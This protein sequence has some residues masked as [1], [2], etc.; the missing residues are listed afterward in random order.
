MTRITPFFA[1]IAICLLVSQPVIGQWSLRSGS[2]R[3]LNAAALYS[4][5]NSIV[6]GG[7]ESN[8]A[9]RFVNVSPDTGST[10]DN[11]SDLVNKQWITSI[12]IPVG[13]LTYRCGRLGTVHRSSDGAKTWD[14]IPIPLSV[15]ARS[16]NSIHF[17]DSEVG[18]VVG[19]NEA[20]DSIQTIIKTSDGGQNWV[21]Q[22]DQ[23]D[24]W[25]K[26]IW[27]HD[28]QTGI[29]AGERGTILKTND[30][31]NNWE[32]VNPPVGTEFSNFNAIYFKDAQNG[33]MVGG[34]PGIDSVQI[35]LETSDGGASWSAVIDQPGGALNGIGFRT[36]QHGFAVGD[37]G[38]ILE[39]TDG[40]A[41]WTELIFPPSFNNLFHLNN[42]VFANHDY[43]LILGDFGQTFRYYA[44]NPTAP[45]VKTYW[46]ED[47]TTGSMVMKGEVN[48][49]DSPTQVWFEYGTDHSLGNEVSATPSSLS[50]N[51]WTEV[52]GLEFLSPGTYYYRVVAENASGINHGNIRHAHI[53]AN[54][55]PNWDFELW[56]TISSKR[57][58]GWQSGFITDSVVSYNATSA[59]LLSG[60]EQ[61]QNEVEA[62]FVHNGIVENNQVLPLVAINLRPDTI[63]GYF[64]YDV[65]AGDTASVA[66]AM[67]FEGNLIAFHFFPI[68]G[69]SSG[70]FE[71]LKFEIE[72]STADTPDSVFI[73]VVSGNI[74]G[75]PS[76]NSS[77]T[78]DDLHFP[79]V[80]YTIENGDFEN[81]ETVGKYLP[82][83]WS[84]PDDR[85]DIISNTNVFQVTDA[86]SGDFG[87]KV[88]NNHFTQHRNTFIHLSDDP[89]NV[90]GPHFPISQKYAQFN[91]YFKFLP[92]NGDSLMMSVSMFNNGQPIGFSWLA[93]DTLV[94]DYQLFELPINYYGSGELIPDSANVR[95]QIFGD[96][97]SGGGGVLFLDNL[98]FDGFYSNTIPNPTSVLSLE[99]TLSDWNLYPNPNTG[100]FQLDYMG[101]E[102][103]GEVNVHLYSLDG[104]A[105]KCST[106]FNMNSPSVRINARG[107]NNGIYL[108]N[109][110][111]DHGREVFRTVII[112]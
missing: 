14:S 106:Q 104:K 87:F 8:D 15:Q 21:V 77:V 37:W 76:V 16:F 40:G 54:P 103:L 93:L 4:Y 6:F 75:E 81:W 105:V 48:P 9:I 24:P 32:S 80:N 111:T 74:L 30:G 83:N 102:Q 26:A 97:L 22:R 31:G 18:Y 98:G 50:G 20:I 108:L 46:A 57:P 92:E 59:V 71:L 45:M 90:D 25:L 107:I 5:D 62:S 69:S 34:L 72:Y 60:Y 89:E 94:Q 38:V 19:G 65:E 55:I 42:V 95:F 73:A 1:A 96:S 29:V 100:E 101:S 109:I 61:S 11:F 12:S 82:Q 78:V 39:T 91:G 27:M 43:G 41:N 86:V 64:N 44:I 99:P 3:N 10:W 110:D 67:F 112:K 51:N 36:D 17:V 33:F 47:I 52:S 85:N 58:V 66:T 79:G 13:Q 56:D 28:D 23:L 53:G 84:T 2:F 63:A 49:N 35:I 70:L 88:I 68:T 7:N